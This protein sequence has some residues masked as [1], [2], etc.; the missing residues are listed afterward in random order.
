[1]SETQLIEQST[2][3]DDAH[4]FRGGSADARAY[5][6][7]SVLWPAKLIVGQHDFN[8]QIWNM[9]LGGARIK[10]DLPLK[11]NATV[12]LAVAGRG[13]IPAKVSWCDDGKVGLAFAMPPEEVRVLFLDR[14]DSLG[15][16]TFNT[17]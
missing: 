3:I 8:C 5:R 2:E 10:I 6:R 12:V 11:D 14:A 1:M 15:F 17:P 16:E 7:R 13:N 9:S 4:T